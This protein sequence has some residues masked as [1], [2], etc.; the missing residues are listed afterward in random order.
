MN[1]IVE[2]KKIK[3]LWLG[4]PRI[5][6]EVLEKVILDGFNIVGVVAQE[7]KPAGRKKQILPVPTKVVAQKYNIPIYQP[8]KI[9]LDYDFIKDIN[10]DLI[11]TLAYG[12]II[13]HG[14]LE[15]PK[16][17]CLNL[18]GSLLPKYRGA[19]PMQ[20][21]LLNGDKKT[22]ITLMEMV[23]EMD[24]GKMYLKEEVRIDDDDNMETL[25]DKMVIAAF[26]ALKNGLYDYLNG[27]NNGEE[28]NLEEVTFTKKIKPEDEKIDF[29]DTAINIHNKVRALNPDPG[30]YFEFNGLNYKVNSTKIINNNSIPNVIVSYDKNGLIIGCK[31]GCIC[32]TSIQKPGKNMLKIQDFYNG[33]RELFKKD[34]II[35]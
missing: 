7:D 6:S 22:G 25:T 30:C 29:N 34:E 21:A 2:P 19:A 20:Y 13:P 32:F 17:G 27:A 10:P 3:I 33:N 28:Q 15:I 8:A 11:I 31:E 18:H 23:D 14:L 9:R 4:T 24:A 35:K 26:N 16:Y 12:Q 5:S 1:L